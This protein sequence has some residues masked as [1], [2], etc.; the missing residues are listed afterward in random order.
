M[1]VNFFK[2]MNLDAVG[3]G[4]SLLCA[5]HCALLPLFLTALPLMGTQILEN[6]Q[7]E[8]ALLGVSFFIGCFALGRGYIRLH[9]R[10][11]PL[12]LFVAGFSLLLA[13]HYLLD[14]GYKESL[15]I[16]LGAIGVMLAHF[17]NIRHGR[18]CKTHKHQL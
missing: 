18:T 13:G 15:V 1:E 3:I 11:L 6:K 12:L 9:R 2:K 4:A 17:I 5:L 7:L 14:G 16:L 8:Y 10:L